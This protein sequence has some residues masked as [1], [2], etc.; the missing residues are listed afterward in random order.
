MQPQYLTMSISKFGIFILFTVLAAAACRNNDTAK[1]DVFS[2]KDTAGINAMPAAANAV[3]S[4]TPVQSS[5]QKPDG[6]ARNKYS[7]FDTILIKDLSTQLWKFDGGIEGPKNI[8]PEDMKGFWMQFHLNGKY[9]KGTYNKI[10]SKG[11]YTVDNLGF[12]EMVPDDPKE[13]KSE[14]QSKFNS[15]MLILIGTEKYRDNHIQ[16]R[17][18]RIGQKP[19]N[20]K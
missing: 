18:S 3:R 16:M 9:E 4:D 20:T 13:K 10:T 5:F 14:W 11:N 1:E 8:T 15:D 12:I 2:Q 17:L 6:M 19:V 7:R